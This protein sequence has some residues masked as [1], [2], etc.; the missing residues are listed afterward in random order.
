MIRCHH[1]KF[2][3]LKKCILSRIPIFLLVFGTVFIT[4]ESFNYLESMVLFL[5]ISERRFMR[6]SAHLNPRASVSIKIKSKKKKK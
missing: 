6:M 2:R 4:A 3:N 5:W 1:L